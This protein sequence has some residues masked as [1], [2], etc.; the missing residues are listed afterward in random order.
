MAEF[1]FVHGASHGAGCWDRVLPLMREAGHQAHAIDLPGHGEDQTP[2][3]EVRMAD[4]LRAVRDATPKGT[5]LVGHS[6]GGYPITL[7]AAEGAPAAALIYLAA[8]VPEPGKAFRDVRAGAINPQVGEAQIVDRDAGVAGTRPER[9]APLFY[10]E[11]S[12]EDQEFALARLTPQPLAV[13]T[14]TV[15]F[16]P[17]SL[18]RHYIRCT[19]DRVVFPAYQQAVSANWSSTFDMACGHSPFFSDPEELVGIFDRIATR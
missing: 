18:P 11:C 6:F 1:L 3:G 4:Y 2:R 12:A 15:D 16:T 14:E 8:L 10:P 17:P 9:A 19:E 13:M 5:Y 7:A